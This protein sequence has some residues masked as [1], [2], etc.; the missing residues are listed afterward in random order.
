MKKNLIIILALV[1]LA[2]VV[3]VAGGIVI[4]SSKSKQGEETIPPIQPGK[5]SALIEEPTTTEELETKT[6]EPAANL[7]TGSY[8]C[9]YTIEEGMKVTTYVKNGKMRTEISLPGDDNNIA[10]YID[11][12]IYQWSEKEK[13]GFFMPVEEAKN[14]PGTEIQ[15]PDEYLYE[16]KNKYKLD[17]NDIDLSD[18]L[19]TLPEDIEFQDLSQILNQ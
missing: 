14:Q 4:F 7:L 1:V 6:E 15:A 11:D 12:K 10:L 5:E 17:C 18:S 19:F 2:L 8:R 3:V 9:T 13:Q 16:I